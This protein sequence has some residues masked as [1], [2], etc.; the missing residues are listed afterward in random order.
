MAQFGRNGF[1]L[2][3]LLPH[4]KLERPQVIAA[5]HALGPLD[6]HRFGRDM[7]LMVVAFTASFFQAHGT[8]CRPVASLRASCG[9]C[10]EDALEFRV[11]TRRNLGVILARAHRRALPFDS[12]SQ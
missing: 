3:L 2:S 8:K 7:T 11:R 10:D 5:C 1:E 6:V 12:L 9:V 4:D